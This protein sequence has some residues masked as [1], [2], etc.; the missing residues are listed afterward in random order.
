ML[1][2]MNKLLRGLFAFLKNSILY[3]SEKVYDS[4]GG[5]YDDIIR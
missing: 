5:R 4:N 2:G 1:A 3:T